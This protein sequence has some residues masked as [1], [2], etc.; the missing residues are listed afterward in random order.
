MN[1]I[2]DVMKYKLG[3]SNSR[4]F[5]LGSLAGLSIALGGFLYISILS[6]FE[7]NLF[8]KVLG[9][10]VFSIGLILI[11]FTQTQLF[12]GNVLMILL[13]PS[14]KISLI[15][16]V[17]N[18]FFVYLGN[19][20][21]SLLFS[22]FIYSFLTNELSRTLIQISE[23][24]VNLLFGDAFV[25]AVLCNILVCLAVSLAILL[26]NNYLKVIG[27]TIPI[28]VFVYFGLEH[29]VANMFF[30]PLGLILKYGIDLKVFPLFVSNI[31]PV[32]IGNI[33]GG[34]ILA[35][36]WKFLLGAYRSLKGDKVH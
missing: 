4:L 33:V 36:C 15:S 14:K 24:K 35:L 23:H 22:I 17:K 2:V 30:I 12:T 32:T 31:V 20:I 18:W 13:F 1:S 9:S 3:S 7:V 25:K 11:I 28:S 26:K 27:I 5:C 34:V 29:S 19:L 21:G 16:V 8:I 6:S 10:A